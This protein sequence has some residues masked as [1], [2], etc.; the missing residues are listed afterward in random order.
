[1]LSEPAPNTAEPD[2]RR[3]RDL[4]VLVIALGAA[5]VLTR[6][7]GGVTRAGHVPSPVLQVLAADAAVWIPLVVGIAWVLRG[8]TASAVRSRLRVDL[9]DV[10]FALG[11]VIVCRA[12][13]V[14]MSISFT[15]T[16]G[17]TPAP[18]LGTPDIGLLVVAA[19]GI[20]LVSPFLEEVLFRGLFQRR[21]A[22]ELTPRTRWLAVLVTAVVFAVLHLLLGASTTTLGGFQ[23]FVTTFLLGLLTG[24]LVAMTNRIGGAILAH[25]V[26]NAVA[27]V[28]TWPR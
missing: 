15:G 27:V 17:L 22:A 9:G 7:V 26:F 11:I 13:D 6:I 20:V 25:A 4:V 18:T 10:V 1:M 14:A 3:Q 2:A 12:V 21:L 28:A 24:T 16:T 8:T 5:V 23:V 19:I